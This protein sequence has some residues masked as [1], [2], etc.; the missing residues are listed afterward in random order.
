MKK[1]LKEKNHENELLN[2]FKDRTHH[3]HDA[4]ASSQSSRTDKKHHWHDVNEWTKD[5]YHYFAEK[6]SQDKRYTKEIT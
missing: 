5:D 4:Y 3:Q 1:N 6:F 2:L